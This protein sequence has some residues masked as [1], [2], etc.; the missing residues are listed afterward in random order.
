MLFC[1]MNF[2]GSPIYY[3]KF[4]FLKKKDCNDSNYSFSEPLSDTDYID[5]KNLSKRE[6]EKQ[7]LIQLEKAQV[8]FKY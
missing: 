1:V 7:A 6:A 4:F 2:F 8:M 3:S 5:E